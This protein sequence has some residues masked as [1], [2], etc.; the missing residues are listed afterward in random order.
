MHN[1]FLLL[2]SNQG[3]R[4][5]NLSRAKQEIHHKI[6]AI[7]QASS[8]YE[9]DPWGFESKGHFLNMVI[10]IDAKLSAESVLEKI[11]DI[12]KELGRVR[13]SK[14]YSS[15]SIDIDILFYDDEIVEKPNLQIP[16]PRLHHRMFTLIP[17]MEISPGK[18]HP[19]FGKAISEL[20]A[21]CTD[22]LGVK[23]FKPKTKAFA[24]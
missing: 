1:C 9:T 22:K 6:G 7:Q 18:I 24:E 11:L 21:E 5:E 4:I 15:R 2:G 3:N 23:K 19:V 10:R 20:L 17:L 14:G 12:E 16:H 13:N 8:V